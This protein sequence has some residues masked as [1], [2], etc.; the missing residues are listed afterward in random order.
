MGR[1]V[2]YRYYLLNSV[3]P[4][5]NH[6]GTSLV[7]PALTYTTA[8][9]WNVGT[10]VA[11]RVCQMDFGTEVARTSA[12][13]VSPATGS[14]PHNVIGNCYVIGPLNGTFHQYPIQ[15]SMSFK[16]IT[17]ASSQVGRLILRVWKGDDPTG[18][19]AV[20][21]TGS[22]ISSSL[23]PALSATNVIAALTASIPVPSF[24]LKGE[25]LFLHTQWG[26]TTAGGNTNADLNT[27]YGGVTASSIVLPSFISTPSTNF[28]LIEE[29]YPL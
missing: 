14:A 17:N 10:N 24:S 5:T 16:A 27:I 13:W 1:P 9:G 25:Y 11:N 19:G 2:T 18:N 21:V 3:F 6:G 29:E 28:K 23:S 15:V 7:P 8:Q 4:E 20:L 26:I 12:Q 22:F